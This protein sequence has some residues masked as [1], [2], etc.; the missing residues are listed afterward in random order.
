M[1]LYKHQKETSKF[2]LIHPRCFITSTPGTGKTVSVLDA[3]NKRK[4]GKMIVIAPKSTIDAVWGEDCRTFYPKLD[5]GIFERKKIK[6]KENYIDRLLRTND[7]AV[8]NVEAIPLILEHSTLLK[9]Q[10]TTI[11][12][13]EFTSVKNRTA[14]RSKAAAKLVKYFKYRILLS[15]TP[16]PNGI[17]DIW[18][19]SLLVDDGVRLGGSFF[20][21]RNSV[22]QPV[23]RGNF[24]TFV[25]WQEIP[26]AADIVADTLRDITIRHELEQVID[27]PKRI[28][29]VMKLDMP[30]KL[31]KAYDAF[32][33]TAILELSSGDDIVA[34]N[35]AVLGNKLLQCAS[36]SIYD[37][38]QIGVQLDSTKYKLITQLVKEREHSLIFYMW[39]H[40]CQELEAEL[41]KENIT[42][43]IINGATSAVQRAAIIKAYQAGRYQTLL[44]QPQA[45]AHGI[46]LTLSTTS[47][48]C[49]PTWNLEHFIQANY[50][51]YR[52]G[53]KKRS[54]VICIAY[55]DTIEERVYQR[56]QEKRQALDDL[57]EILKS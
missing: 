5:I 22:C 4:D 57:L 19:P 6:Q 24:Q 32:K 29:R 56:L 26:G 15:G 11:A 10:Y 21:F 33:A 12:I 37:E 1:K 8:F 43:N 25:E 38:N 28:H 3:F 35:K 41:H 23:Q 31:R 36:G 48:W 17:L 39:N 50:R 45:A 52:I 55:R 42:Y 16:T 44:L 51:D 47:I 27:M 30:P 46:T 9:E 14:A 20:Y 49:S 34:V 7:I 54:E 18:H 40:Q 2:Q 53:Q 13:D